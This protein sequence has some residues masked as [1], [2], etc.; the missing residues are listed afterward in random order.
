MPGQRCAFF[1][2]FDRHLFDS[3]MLERESEVIFQRNREEKT[4]VT[5]G[6]TSVSLNSCPLHRSTSWGSEF[7]LFPC[8]SKR[9]VGVSI[10]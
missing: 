6:Q 10:A 5:D 1:A 9:L 2:C 4:H 7:D 3:A 8:S